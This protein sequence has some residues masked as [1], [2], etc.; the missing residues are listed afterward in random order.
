MKKDIF[1][2]W[3]T[4]FFTGLAIVL[5]AVVSI[6]VI[7]WFFFTVSNITDTLLI[8]IPREYTHE[9]NGFGPMF[10]YWKLVAL[11]LAVILTAIVGRLARNYLGKKAIEWVDTWLLRVP[12]LNKLY[13]TTKQVNEALTSGSKGSFKTVVMVEFPRTG[14][15]SIGFIT[16]EQLGEIERKAGQKLVSVF[17]PTTPQPN[18]RLSRSRP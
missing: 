17:I 10:W 6:A 15:Y 16:G 8:F 3:R 9:N 7:F 5:P 2:S 1:A 18:L 4:N 11:I 12:L 13:G 14:A